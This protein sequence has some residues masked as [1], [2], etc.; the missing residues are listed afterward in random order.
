[1]T[2]TPQTCRLPPETYDAVLFDM[3]G[4]ITDTAEAH[5]DAW[6]RLFDDFL[7]DRAQRR[8]EPFQPFDADSDYRNYVDGIPRYEGVRR[9]LASRGIEL[10]EGD[11]A[12]PPDSETVHGLGN[13]KNGYFRQWLQEHRV[14][15][16]PG[17]VA[18]IQAL[19]EAGMGTAVFSASRNAQAVL[20]SAGVADLF[21]VRIDGNDAH[22]QGLPGKPDPA[23]LLEAARRLGATP[24]RTAIFEDALAGVE[25]GAHGGFACVIGV[26]RSGNADALRQ[27]GADVVVDDPGECLVDHMG[28][29]LPNALDNLDALDRFIAGRPVVALL[30]YDGTLTPIVEDYERAYLPEPMRATL[31]KL[32]EHHTV[33]VISGRDLAKVRGFVQL[34]DVLYAGSHGFEIAGPEGRIATLEKGTELLPVLDD[35]ENALRQGIADVDGA[36]IERKRFSIA[37][38]YRRVREADRP[39]VEAAVDYVLTLHSGLRKGHGK[40]VYEI[41]PA[42]DWDKGRA[43]CWLLDQLG[44]DPNTTVPLYIGDDVTDEDAFRA[45]EGKGIGIAVREHVVAETTADYR[46]ADPDEVRYFLDWLTQVQ[47]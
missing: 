31:S 18:L 4:V 47:A 34:D 30:D 10:P 20:D 36:A 11:E 24:E 1:M 13:R 29:A 6:K 23:V 33:A 12:D 39:R 44:L 15:T 32:A 35:A 16:F 40:K 14:K 9:F 43:V 26:D 25:A 41:Q 27:H 28:R 21:D 46:L 19:R 38:H 3:D 7:K 8:G 2:P 45:L 17:T 5:A 37:V 22:E 42:I